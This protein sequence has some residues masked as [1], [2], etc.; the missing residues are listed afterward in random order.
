[1][2]FQNGDAENIPY[3]NEFFDIVI[4]VESSHCY[5]SL[6]RFFMDVNRVLKNKGVFYYMD[7]TP[8][9]YSDPCMYLSTLK[10]KLSNS[11]FDIYAYRDITEQ[12]LNSL[13]ATHAEKELFLQ[14]KGLKKDRYCDFAAMIG[15]EAYNYF[16]KGIS[17]YFLFVL[18]KSK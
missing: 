14:K 8:A 10:N 13:N 17:I 4:N 5:S 9:I 6:D 2:Y 18:I 3:E 15:S 11:G 16:K 7:F 12:V 1:M